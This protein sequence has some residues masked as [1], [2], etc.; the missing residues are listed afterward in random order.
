MSQSPNSPILIPSV[1]AAKGQITHPSIKYIDSSQE[2]RMWQGSMYYLAYTPYPYQ[3]G[4]LENPCIAVS[5]DGINWKEPHERINPVATNYET[6][7]D[8]LK[9]PE[10][11]YNNVRNELELWY[12]GRVDSTVSDNTPLTLFRKKSPDGIHWS[13][14]EV[15][16]TFETL[17]LVSPMILFEEGKYRMWGIHYDVNDIGLYYT[18]SYDCK[19]WT[20]YS[21]VYVQDADKT[22]MWHGDICRFHNRLFLVW[23]SK[24]TIRNSKSHIYLA[25]SDDD[26]KT[27]VKSRAIIDNKSGWMHFYRPTM[28]IKE[29]NVLLYYGIVTKD[30]RWYIGMS[31]GSNINSLQPVN[32]MIKGFSVS[33]WNSKRLA[34]IIKN[35]FN[36]RNMIMFVFI[37][38]AMFASS[39]YTLID[40]LS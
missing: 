39:V 15:V 26:G 36:K 17:K 24:E 22:K 14:F 30:N 32:D 7:C 35:N 5:D 19:S 28:M 6:N 23:C 38:I 40:V 34:V 4:A 33:Q 11:V 12:L 13:E 18:E 20:P 21:R 16:L 1:A 31:C 27:F 8:E 10:L 25:E 9:D 37:I 2:G 29:D 3:N